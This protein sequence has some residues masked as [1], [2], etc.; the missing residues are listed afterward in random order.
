MYRQN[1][2]EVPIGLSGTYKVGK[3][4][5]LVFGLQEL[6]NLLIRE[7][8]ARI[9]PNFQRFSHMVQGLSEVE[10]SKLVFWSLFVS[11]ENPWLSSSLATVSQIGSSKAGFYRQ[12]P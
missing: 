7:P 10:L 1:G 5:I 3:I 6:F 11:R 12:S 4:T 9:E 8:T 2:S